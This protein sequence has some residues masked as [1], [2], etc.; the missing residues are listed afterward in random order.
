MKSRVLE[1]Q[2]KI[3]IRP[4]QCYVSMSSQ[5]SPFPSEDHQTIILGIMEAQR[6]PRDEEQRDPGRLASILSKIPSIPRFSPA[7]QNPPKQRPYSMTFKMAKMS[8]NG[9]VNKTAHD[10]SKQ[11]EVNDFRSKGKQKSV[12]VNQNSNTG[13]SESYENRNESNGHKPTTRQGIEPVVAEDPSHSEEAAA[14][15]T[16]APPVTEKGLR[17]H[18]KKMTDDCYVDLAQPLSSDTQLAWDTKIHPWLETNLPHSLDDLNCISAE[19]VMAG[20]TDGSPMDP[21]ILFMCRDLAQKQSIGKLLDRCPSIPRNV[22]RRIIVF[23]VLKCTSGK[24]GANRPTERFLGRGIEI[25]FDDAHNA[26]VLYAN[27]ART[28][29][30]ASDEPS[31]FCTIGGML[32]V[33][34]T[35][36]GLTTAHPL[37]ASGNE[38]QATP[39]V[40]PG[41]QF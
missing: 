3:S 5:I 31:V 11:N 20:T 38:S 12:L 19:C 35:F 32:T 34:G 39:T 21:T 24:L 13:P 15:A 18:V 1:K 26:H 41:M 16:A 29:P 17:R 33:N 25:H 4:L 10:Q 28:I 23:D 30:A 40:T 2:R 36:Y 8:K 6:R 22:R 14:S 7:S 9:I 27:I 37:A